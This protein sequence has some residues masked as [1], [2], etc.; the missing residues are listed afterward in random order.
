[1]SQQARRQEQQKCHRC[2]GSHHE[3][4][5]WTHRKPCPVCGTKGQKVCKKGNTNKPDQQG[6]D[7]S[8]SANAANSAGRMS[9]FDSKRQSDTAGSK[10]SQTQG[11]Q[12][13]SYKNVVR[14]YGLQIDN[15]ASANLV[16]ASG[17]KMPIIGTTTMI[18]GYSGVTQ[19]LKALIAECLTHDMIVSWRDCIKFNI[20]HKIFLLPPSAGNINST[21]NKAEAIK[22]A[23]YTSWESTRN[24]RHR[25]HST[26]HQPRY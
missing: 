12:A 7:N 15:S 26:F 14:R 16:N 18:A 25:G 11:Q 17:D 20:L 21:D 5:C 19:P 22:L 13:Q 3:Q 1:M 9:S 6:T 2:K 10:L 23:T 24:Q 8:E 4:T